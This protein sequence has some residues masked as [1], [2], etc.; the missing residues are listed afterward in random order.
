MRRTLVVWRRLGKEHG[1]GQS[2][3]INPSEVV[4]A[5][6]S[7]KVDRFRHTP[8]NEYCSRQLSDVVISGTGVENMGTS[9]STLVYYL[10]GGIGL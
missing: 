3:R 8:Q 10:P 9:D 6:I 4:E 2:F 5:H 1:E 7:S